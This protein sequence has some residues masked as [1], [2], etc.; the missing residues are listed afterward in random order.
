MAPAQRGAGP[1]TSADPA[2]LA[3]LAEHV[4]REAGAL[5]LAARKAGVAQVGTKSTGT[6]MVTEHDRASER[7]IAKL[8]RDARPGDGMLGE[9]GSDRPSTTGI[10]WVV[11][12]IDGTTNFLYA[13]PGYAVSVAAEDEHGAVAACVHA[14]AWGDTW[15]AARGQGATCNG[16]PVRCSTERRLSQALVATGFGYDPQERARQAAVLP[17]LLPRVR[18]IRRFGAASVDLCFAGDGRVDAY[19]ERNLAP[20]D[21]RAG[22]LVA[23]EA[24]CMVTD[25]TGGP[26]GAQG[27]LAANP[28]LHGPLMELLAEAGA[29]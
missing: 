8:L 13:L 17:A 12:P 7:L 3:R 10:T 22:A 20:W 18:D 14:P 28:G 23:A 26:P 1:L 15:V 5:I 4:A 27:V 11:D 19:F 21:L 24:G 6:D 29:A 9:E 16:Q 2:D 25:F